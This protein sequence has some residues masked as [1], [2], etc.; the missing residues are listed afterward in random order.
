MSQ[1]RKGDQVRVHYTGYLHD[2]SVFDSTYESKPLEF[3]IGQGE[4]IE[5]F[6]KAIIG[7]NLGN[8]KSVTIPPENAYGPYKIELVTVIDRS[9]I[10]RDIDPETG[11]RLKAHTREGVITH[12]TVTGI[13]EKTVTLDANHPLAG[14]ELTFEI[15][16]LEIL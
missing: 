5:G 1:A 9:R 16:L 8:I 7:M 14:E 12:V 2:G 15:K 11:M 4:V 13:D 3:T 10:P 6:E